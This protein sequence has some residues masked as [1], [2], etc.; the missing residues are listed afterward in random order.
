MLELILFGML[1]V[2][3][4]ISVAWWRARKRRHA[5]RM[6]VLR[7]QRLCD[8]AVEATLQRLNWP[9][10]QG[11]LVSQPVAD[12]WGHGVMAF[13]YELTQ[14][15]R[16]ITAT[17]FSQALQSIDTL[18]FKVTDWWRRADAVHVDVACLVNAATREYVHDLQRVQ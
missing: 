17:Q 2:I 13:T 5:M 12:V 10:P 18:P 11:A 6:L 15:D 8:Q 4:I 7:N 14:P 16:V 1:I 3:A 9:Q